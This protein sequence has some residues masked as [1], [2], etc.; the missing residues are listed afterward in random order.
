MGYEDFF[1]NNE[2]PPVFVSLQGGRVYPEKGTKTVNQNDRAFFSFQEKQGGGQG[3]LSLEVNDPTVMTYVKSTPDMY[4]FPAFEIKGSKGMIG[5]ADF[6]KVVKPCLMIKDG[7][8]F[9]IHEKGNVIYADNK[10]DLD[11]RV[12]AYLG[13]DQSQVIETVTPPPTNRYVEEPGNDFVEQEKGGKMSYEE[14]EAKM[15]EM[16]AQLKQ[17]YAWAKSQGMPSV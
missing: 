15:K 13:I 6:F 14:M 2:K 16:E 5:T 12:N 1:T 4:L 9:K 11:Q 8:S 7:S 3:E 10:F 17:V